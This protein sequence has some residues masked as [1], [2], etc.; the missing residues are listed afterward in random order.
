MTTLQDIAHSVLRRAA[1][2]DGDSLIGT[3]GHC[4]TSNEFDGRIGVRVSSIFVILVGSFVGK[5]VTSA[6]SCCLLTDSP[7]RLV[8]RL[9]P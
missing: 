7:R 5:F 2:E 9:R 1:E 4:D 3:P 8:S 6:L